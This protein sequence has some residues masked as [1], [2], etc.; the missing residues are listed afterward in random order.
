VHAG[1]APGLSNLAIANMGGQAALTSNAPAGV[2][3]IR[4]AAVNAFGGSSP[5]NE[6]IL[7][8]GNSAPPTS[9]L[10]STPTPPPP[11]P[12]VCGPTMAASGQAT[13]RCNNGS[14]SCSQNHLTGHL[15]TPSG[16]S[17][18]VMPERA[19]QLSFGYL[20]AMWPAEPVRAIRSVRLRTP[21]PVE[22]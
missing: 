7:T 9:P 6:I 1:S 15:P 13:A 10:P 11:A 12:N 17:M 19:L 5:S 14:Y 18:V 3:Y 21:G 4:V 22:T 2:Y 8:V 20:R 16:A